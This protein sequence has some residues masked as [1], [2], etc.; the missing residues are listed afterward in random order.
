MV[1]IRIPF[2]P[3]P[4]PQG[5]LASNGFFTLPGLNLGVFK[6]LGYEARY[7]I[8]EKAREPREQR[9]SSRHHVLTPSR[10]GG[11]TAVVAT[12]GGGYG[13]LSAG[14]LEN[15]KSHVRQSFP[16]S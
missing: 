6:A 8:N 3:D 14:P 10:S 16:Q 1:R 9:R 2:R 12:T 7:L 13:I 11:D 4:H 5:S 15:F